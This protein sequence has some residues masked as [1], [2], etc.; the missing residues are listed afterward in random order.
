[1]S[2][3]DYDPFIAPRVGHLQEAAAQVSRA[4]GGAEEADFSFGDLLDVLNPLHHIPVVGNLYRELTG[5]EI[6]GTA[7]II[8]GGLY[9][10]AFG[11]VGA[12]FN[13]ILDD[14]TGRDMAETALAVVTGQ[15]LGG[16]TG[17]ST[18]VAEASPQQQTATAASTE[19]QDAEPQEAGG[20]SLA[21]TETA[22]LARG[23]ETAA[24]APAPVDPDLLT[25]QA[26]LSALAADMRATARPAA[27]AAA[28]PDRQLANRPGLAPNNFM[29]VSHRDFAGPRPQTTPV[30]RQLEAAAVL[31][32]EPSA[33]EADPVAPTAA[34]APSAQVL[35]KSAAADASL[36]M[37]AQ[38]SDADFAERMM[39]ALI[40]YEALTK[41]QAEAVSQTA[42]QS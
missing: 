21:D 14:A 36:L 12:A 35:P 9:G 39:Q 20:Q 13:Q 18:N 7:R 23:S 31:S 34:T 29:P 30:S 27:E 15:E 28:S 40:K 42:G 37:P 25:G 3:T 8:G 2:A 38:G 17:D 5:D 16:S 22:G 19:P 1:M 32:N 41:E 4:R 6:G 24:A 11:M 26:A 10:G 33:A